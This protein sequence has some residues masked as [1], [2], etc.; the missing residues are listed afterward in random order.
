MT[1][2]LQL[3]LRRTMDTIQVSTEM[4]SKIMD[5]S[6]AIAGRQLIKLFKSLDDVVHDKR[7]LEMIINWSPQ[8]G[9]PL[10]TMAPWLK[11]AQRVASLETN[12]EGPFTLS[13]AQADLLYKRLGDSEFKINGLNPALTDFLLMFYGTIGKHPDDMTKEVM[14]DD[15][16]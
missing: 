16:T 14:Y 4:V 7:W 10:T 2:V 8:E 6:P 9:L 5:M 1:V 3:K 12:R 13:D 11:L 15:E